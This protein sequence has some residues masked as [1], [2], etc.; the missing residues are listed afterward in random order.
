VALITRTQVIKR[1][2]EV[3]FATVVDGGDFAS[4]NPTV[5]AS[6]RL[7]RGEIGQG[8]RFEWDLRGFGKVVQEL[9]EFEP[10]KRVRIVPRLKTL[11]GGHRFLFTPQ[12]GETRI[13]HELEMTPKGAF[14]LLAPMMGLVGR[15]NL[16]DTA[17]ALQAH[18][19]GGA[20]RTAEY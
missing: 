4:W 7:D 13:D 17:D 8:S 19:E 5:R 6:R 14:R 9:E 1:P 11:E 12:G 2:V 15:K 3:V 10:N 18:V 20:N 16:R